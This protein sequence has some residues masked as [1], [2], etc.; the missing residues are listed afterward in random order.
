M[1]LEIQ[2]LCQYWKLRL[3][4]YISEKDYLYIK[5]KIL[6]NNE[7]TKLQLANKKLAEKINSKFETVY[8]SIL[9]NYPLQYIFEEAYFLDLVLFVDDRVLIPRPETEELVVSILETN[10]PTEKI[11]VLDIGSGSGCIPI[12]LAR[13]RPRWQIE[14]IDTSSQALEVAKINAEKYKTASVLFK[15]I[16]FLTEKDQLGTYDL[17]VSNPPYI[18]KE[19]MPKMDKSVIDFEPSIALFTDSDPLEFYRHIAEFAET[20]LNQNGSIFCEINEYYGLETKAIFERKFSSVEIKKDM[21]GKDRILIIEN[22]E[23]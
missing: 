2:E 12:S 15:N 13:K 20:N 3:L 22:S 6:K 9:L 8:N 19:E 21:Q 18:S 11:K 17:I 16:D 4:E 7:Y 23:K 14:S 5:N 1:F 10:I